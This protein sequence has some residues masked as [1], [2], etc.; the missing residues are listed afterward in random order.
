VSDTTV[1]PFGPTAAAASLFE[2]QLAPSGSWQP[3]GLVFLCSSPHQRGEAAVDGTNCG[4]HESHTPTPWSHSLAITHRTGGVLQSVIFSE[5]LVCP[6][7]YLAGRQLRL[8]ARGFDR[9]EL[10]AEQGTRF[11]SQRACSTFLF[12]GA[13]RTWCGDCGVHSANIASADGVLCGPNIMRY[14]ARMRCSTHC[15]TPCCDKRVWREVGFQR[16]R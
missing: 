14:A 16:H 12:Y 8:R 5:D 2:T 4:R 15:S 1:E 11:L 7:R 6:P 10:S 9:P 3:D 13:V